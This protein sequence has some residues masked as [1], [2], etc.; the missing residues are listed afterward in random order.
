MSSKQNV[1]HM[2]SSMVDVISHRGPDFR[3]LKSFDFGC[4]GH[5][6]LTIIDKHE[7]ANQPFTAGGGNF[8]IVYNGEIYNFEELRHELSTRYQFVTKSDT[9]VLLAGVM[10]YGEKFI[11]R[12]NGMFAFCIV[13]HREQSILLGRDRFGQ[14]PLFYCSFGNNFYFASEIKSLICCG[15]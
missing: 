5:A 8:T 9:E 1:D 15:M 11:N 12:L 13:N 14:K 4:V 6:R 2:V 7:R 10:I 3:N